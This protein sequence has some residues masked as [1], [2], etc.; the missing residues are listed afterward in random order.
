LAETEFS[1]VRFKGN[2]ERAAKVYKGAQ[3][4]TGEDIAEIALWVSNLPDHVNI[5]SI[6]VMPTSQAWGPIAIHR[7]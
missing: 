5:N 3:P 1:I 2:K 6:E 7:E 4:L